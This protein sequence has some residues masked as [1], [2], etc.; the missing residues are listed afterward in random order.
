M[1]VHIMLNTVFT[2]PYVDFILSSF[3]RSQ[4]RFL[5]V[6]GADPD[7]IPTPQEPEVLDRVRNFRPRSATAAMFRFLARETADADRIVLHGLFDPRTTVFLYL[8]PDRCRRSCWVIWGADLHI[9]QQLRAGRA[10]GTADRLIRGRV[11]KN[12]AFVV[13]L[14]P[15]DVE[16]LNEAYGLS[17]AWTIGAYVNVVTAEHL[18]AQPQRSRR[19]EEPVRILVGNSA[20]ASNN[21]ADVL[22]VLS[23]FRDESMTVLVPLSYGDPE[24]ADAVR[25]IGRR[26]LGDRFV[27]LDSF[28]P[29]EEYAR[30]LSTIDVAVFNHTRQQAL[31]NYFALAYL[32]VKIYA[33]V[34]GLSARYLT[35]EMGIPTFDVASLTSIGFSDLPTMEPVDRDRAREGARAFYDPSR[36]R[37]VWER[38]FFGRIG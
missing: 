28:L 26:H 1:I 11:F 24:Y 31:G 7:E 3:D 36:R 34:E 8:R 6:G 17:K 38:V 4:H 9:Y 5:I 18:E 29:P 21:H 2:K 23:R 13:A 30:L 15:G 33:R 10:L 32:G 35:G 20:S 14:A 25:E 16:V 12:L 19:S 22:E 27:A 37:D